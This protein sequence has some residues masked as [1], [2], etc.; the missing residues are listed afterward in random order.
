MR[1]VLLLLSVLLA[2]GGEVQAQNEG[3]RGQ[4]KGPFSKSASSK[5]SEKSSG[6]VSRE[7]KISGRNTMTDFQAKVSTKRKNSPYPDTL[8]YADVV[9]CYSWLVGLGD[10]IS[11][12]TAEHLPF[13]FRLTMPN[14]HGHYQLVQAMHGS[15][16]TSDHP[17]SP[18]ILD[19]DSDADGGTG[20]WREQ[21]RKVGQWFLSSDRYG[22]EVVEERAYEATENGAA[23]VYICQPVRNDSTHV[24]ISYSDAWGLPADMNEH[25]DYVYGSVAYVT[26]DSSGCDA[27]IDYLDGAGYRKRDFSGVDQRR[28]V[29]DGRKRPVLVTSNNLTGSRITDSRGIC[30]FRYVYHDGSPERY[31]IICID[32]DLKPVRRQGI[33]TEGT[34]TYVRCDVTKDEWGREVEYAIM[35]ADGLPD[36]TTAGIHRIIKNYSDSGELLSTDYFDIN[37]NKIP[38]EEWL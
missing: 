37:G 9:R 16:L 36:V 28:C 12:Q 22:Q 34:L 8:L 38:Y 4:I 33:T 25:P 26:Y 14:E 2:F 24:T 27:V 1:K 5:D 23:L 31:S 19:K 29:Y 30:G 18:Y 3:I 21:L 35:T 11:R 32:K 15:H 10:P 7:S 20:G 6:Y 17:L 13:Y